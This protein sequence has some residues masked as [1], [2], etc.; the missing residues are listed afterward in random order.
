VKL[1]DGAL[2]IADRGV[3]PG[4]YLYYR[5]AWGAEPGEELVMEA[6]AKV[7]SGSSWVIFTDGWAQA[8]LGLW[9]DHIDLWGR[10]DIRYNMDTTRDFHL[11][12]IVAKGTDLR[13]YVD[14]QLRLDGKG[15][16]RPAAAGGRNELAFGASNSADLGEA[17]WASVRAR[18][19]GQVCYDAVLS[20][21]YSRSK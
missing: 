19:R 10:S 8:R 3:Q 20:V 2:F 7:V 13:V 5:Y 4:D 11:Y 16:F 18:V 17:Q 21:E 14:G 6:R 12:R 15:A 9:S 1:V